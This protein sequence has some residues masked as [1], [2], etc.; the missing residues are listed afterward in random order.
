[1]NSSNLAPRDDGSKT[2]VIGASQAGLATGYHLRQRGLPFQIVDAGAE[3]G[4]T[5]RKPVGTRFD[6]SPRRNTTTCRAWISPAPADTYPGKDDIADF[7]R[8]YAER[9]ELPVR[10]NTRITRVTTN[11]GSYLAEAGDETLEA[12]Q[13]VVATGP[14]QV[15]FVPLI[16]DDLD[17][18]VTQIHSVD[19]RDPASFPGEKTLVVG[20]ATR[21]AKSPS[22]SRR[23]GKLRSPSASASR[24][25]PSAAWAATCGGG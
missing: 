6:Y 14:F 3:I 1:M 8:N 24:P 13:V 12:A 23:R 4:E 2:L 7:L 19:Y 9:F 22:S 21:V 15:P 18:A 25:F 16:A 20:G 5:W 17:P 11:K 10:L